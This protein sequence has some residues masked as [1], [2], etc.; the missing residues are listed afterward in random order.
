MRASFDSGLADRV[1]GVLVGLATGDA[2]GAALEFVPREMVRKRFPLGLREMTASDLWDQGEYTDDTQMALLLADSLLENQRLLPFDVARRF[3]HWIHSAKD[4]GLQTR[5]VAGMADYLEHPEECAF[6]YYAAHP[7]SSAGNGAVMRCAPV[8]LFHLN[9]RSLLIDASRQSARLTHF[10]P[11]A[12]S[13][14]VVLN[15]W[16]AEAIRN[17]ARDARALALQ[18]LPAS[19]QSAWRRLRSIQ[20]LEEREIQSTGFTVHTL[21]AAAWSFLTTKS[22]EHAVVRAVN[23]GD[24]ADTVGAVTGALAGAFYG[25]SAIPARWRR[26]LKDEA[27]I[28]GKALALAGLSGE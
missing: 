18:A 16:I 26:E 23:L 27:M 28:R 14:C 2:L 24:D 10:D 13:S 3:R 1:A 9:S 5:A 25:Y 17:G 8:A 21:E 15:L 6:Q 11:L 19:E 20:Q 12:Q 4:V 7:G 22:F